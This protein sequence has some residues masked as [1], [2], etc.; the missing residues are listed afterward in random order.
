MVSPAVNRFAVIACGLL[1]G[2]ARGQ[3]P[4][5]LPASQPSSQPSKVEQLIQ[6]LESDDW[7]VRQQAAESLGNAGP[8]MLPGLRRIIET[9]ADVELRSTLVAAVKRIEESAMATPSLVTLHAK[10]T[11]AVEVLNSLGGQVDFDIVA[12]STEWLADSKITLDVERQPFW[13]V[14]NQLSSQWPVRVAPNPNDVGRL[15]IFEKGNNYFTERSCVTGPFL[16]CPMLLQSNSILDLLQPVPQPKYRSLILQ[17][18]VLAEPKV[19]TSRLSLS[20]KE[21]VDENGKAFTGVQVPGMVARPQMFPLSQGSTVSLQLTPPADV[22]RKIARLSGTVSGR[23]PLTTRQVEVAGISDAAEH[24]VDL[25]GRRVK[26]TV[27]PREKQYDVKIVLPPGAN[28]QDDL[29]LSQVRDV[30]LLDA[31][32]VTLFRRNTAQTMNGRAWQFTITYVRE[33]TAFGRPGKSAGEAAK[34]VWDLPIDYKDVE[35][36]FELSQI[37]LSP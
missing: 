31:K 27:T 18:T 20:M 33:S 5:T 15:T 9:T 23:V 24:A 26:V 8:A 1:I 17:L 4:S 6:A 29:S 35:L 22:G 30:S 2:I 14:M 21:A 16:V 3:S 11:P 19:R 32:G 34:L 28:I 37:P 7:K 36:P 12:D 13:A 10:D 25:G